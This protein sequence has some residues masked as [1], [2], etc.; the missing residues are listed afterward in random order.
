MRLSGPTR[1]HAV[2]EEAVRYLLFTKV[3]SFTAM[4]YKE[5]RSSVLVVGRVLY[6]SKF[7]AIWIHDGTD[8]EVWVD[9]TDLGHE[10]HFMW[11]VTTVENG[12]EITQPD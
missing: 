1:L 4:C 10:N 11:G 5:G 12:L 8:P 2:I 7:E 6:N 3:S 9:D